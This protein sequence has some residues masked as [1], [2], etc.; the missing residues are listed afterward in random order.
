MSPFFL[1]AARHYTISAEVVSEADK[2]EAAGYIF[3]T[4]VQIGSASKDTEA[5]KQLKTIV[6]RISF[7]VVEDLAKFALHLFKSLPKVLLNLVQD[8]KRVPM[9]F[10]PLENQTFLRGEYS[11]SRR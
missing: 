2:K 11:D 10:F 6:L 7:Y 5:Q 1:E 3:K 4:R 8:L 9:I